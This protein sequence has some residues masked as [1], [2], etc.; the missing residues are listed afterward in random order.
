MHSF[1]LIRCGTVI[2]EGYW[3]PLYA[4]KKHRL[5]SVSKSFTAVA[6]GM[7]IDEGKITLE[8]KV[9]DYFPEY[10]PGNPHSTRADATKWKRTE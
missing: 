2:A 9:A 8:D 1:M 5:Y 10:I 6:V 7:M 3:K 4:E